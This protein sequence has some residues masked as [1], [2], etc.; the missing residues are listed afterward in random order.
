MLPKTIKCKKSTGS[1]FSTMKIFNKVKTKAGLFDF[2]SPH[3]KDFFFLYQ[4]HKGNTP[5]KINH[6][7]KAGNLFSHR[8][9]VLKMARFQ[10]YFKRAHLPPVVHLQ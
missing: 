2:M 1:V 5:L 3:Q 9:N 7:L 4:T 6:V 10:N 8:N